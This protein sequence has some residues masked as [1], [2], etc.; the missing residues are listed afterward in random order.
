[1][2]A[3]SA[4]VHSAGKHFAQPLTAGTGKNVLFRSKRIIEDRRI[5]IDSTFALACASLNI[6]PNRLGQTHRASQTSAEV[7]LTG[8]DKSN[9]YYA[10]PPY[11]AQQYSRFYH[12]LETITDYRVGPLLHGNDTTSGL[13]T[14]ERYKSAFSSKAKAGLAFKHCPSSND[15]RAIG[16]LCNGVSG[17][18]V[19]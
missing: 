9:L 17:P 14:R 6:Q 15:L 4:A 12:L 5:C 18:S 11:T 1:M 7:F 8:T 16:V 19:G 2:S 3:A 10:D 13:Y